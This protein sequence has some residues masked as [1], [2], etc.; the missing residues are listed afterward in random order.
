M[1]QEDL[2]DGFQSLYETGPHRLSTA[3]PSLLTL[4]SEQARRPGL[5]SFSVRGKRRFLLEDACSLEVRC[6]VANLVTLKPSPVLAYGFA[7]WWGIPSPVTRP[8][9]RTFEDPS[10]RATSLCVSA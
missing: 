8:N 9:L 1:T 5:Q 10:R 7:G 4:E 3:T 6:L 2:V